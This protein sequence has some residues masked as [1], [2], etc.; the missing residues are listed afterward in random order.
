MVR[1]K[2]RQFIVARYFPNGVRCQKCGK[3][4][5][6]GVIDAHHPDPSVKE[7]ILSE[8]LNNSAL[9]ERP[10]LIA[11]LDQCQM[12]CARCHGNFHS[13]PRLSHED[14]YSGT[15]KKKG[16]QIDCRKK[17]VREKFGEHC[18]ECG[19]WL[20]P[21]EMVFHHRDPAEK[22]GEPSDMMRMASKEAIMAEVAK[23]D[24]LCRNCHRGVHPPVPTSM[25]E[26]TA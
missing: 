19:D 1:G 16:R 13:D 23:C 17:M 18:L 2:N 22:T 14:T 3:E 21:K 24:I 7:Y 15:N 5:S 25:S 9:Q 11:E 20:Y 8:I 10:E 12:L 4:F 6:L 26:V